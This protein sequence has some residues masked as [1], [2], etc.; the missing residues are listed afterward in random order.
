MG[1]QVVEF[2]DHNP[3]YP[4]APPATSGTSASVFSCVRGKPLILAS[5][6]AN[7]TRFEKAL[8]KLLRAL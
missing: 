8:A 4:T 2:R 1:T 6:A 5:Q 3:T 7:E